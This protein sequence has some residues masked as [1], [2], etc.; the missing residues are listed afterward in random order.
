[1]FKE[2]LMS[3]VGKAAIKIPDKVTVNM[4]N[5]KIDVKGPKGLMHLDLPTLV[6]VSISNGEVIVSR[7]S[8]DGD[9]RACHGLIRNLIG[10][11]VLGVSEGF[12]RTLEI[13]GVGYRAEL[14]GK[15]LILS[16]GFSH[17][18]NFAIPEG[19]SITVNKQTNLV[20]EGIDKQLV[21]ETAARIRRLRPPE[22]YKGKGIKY[23]DEII[24]KK[25]GKAAA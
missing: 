18:I 23:S 6:D 3:R 17:P 13:N 5:R 10:N 12:S 4:Q 25:A 22:P 14:K 15:D 16:L 1:L 7:D 2:E 24:K 19:I 20:L 9:A 21:G 11:M 8:D